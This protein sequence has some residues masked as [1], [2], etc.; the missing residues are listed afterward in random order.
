VRVDAMGTG[1]VEE[2][3]LVS[4]IR[5]IFPLTPKGI[6][7]YLDLRRPIYKQTAAYGHYGRTEPEFTWEKAT[8]ADTLRKQV[9]S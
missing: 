9:G 8:Q 2:A 3:K 1:K 6:I 7:E 4:A 5:Q